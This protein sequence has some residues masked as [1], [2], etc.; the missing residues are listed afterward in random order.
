MLALVAGAAVLLTSHRGA[1]AYCTAP[2][3]SDSVLEWQDGECIGYSDGK[4]VFGEHGNDRSSR[5][6]DNLVAVQHLIARQ[7]ACAEVLHAHSPSSNRPFVT[8][9]YF[10][11]FSAPSGAASDWA[12]SQVAGLEG[13]LTWQRH[14]NIISYRSSDPSCAAAPAETNPQNSAAYLGEKQE[15]GGP[16]VRVVLANGGSLMHS[17]DHVGQLLVRFAKK[18]EENVASVIGLHRT[19]ATTKQA[20]KTLGRNGIITLAT[21]LSGD[22][23]V[24][25]SQSYFPLV[26][27]NRRQAL[28]VA[29]Y[30]AWTNRRQ[31][32]VYFPSNDCSGA[33]TPP[34]DDDYIKD[35]VLD[36]PVQAAGIDVNGLPLQVALHGW[37][38]V[39]ACQSHDDLLDYFRRECDRIGAGGDGGN[40]LVYFAGRPENFADFLN[41]MAGCLETSTGTS[42]N[43]VLV[44][45]DDTVTGY[46]SE[47]AGQ[48][49]KQVIFRLVS[50]APAPMLAGASCV[51]GGLAQL[52][53]SPKFPF[54]LPSALPELCTRLNAMFYFTTNSPPAPIG[55]SSTPASSP[56]QTDPHASTTG[57][58]TPT[59]SRPSANW[60]DEETALAYD[61]AKLTLNAV[62]RTVDDPSTM[63]DLN[64]T[65]QSGRIDKLNIPALT[66]WIRTHPETGATGTSDYNDDGT[67]DGKQL[68]VL[69]INLSDSTLPDARWPAR[70]VTNLEA[71]PQSTCKF[72]LS[73]TPPRATDC[74]G[75]LL[76]PPA[77]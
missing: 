39:V 72:V 16:I 21:A 58:D 32:D 18:P 4:F 49:S 15:Q 36:T 3:G 56:L 51:S 31:I 61:A 38:P 35:L 64:A 68:A 8:L 67:S 69:R 37:K 25:L 63:D 54:R 29:R 47:N 44:L 27:Q 6:V 65:C 9:V 53:D 57:P 77:R 34:E 28:L 75:R 14:Q 24:G 5:S 10:G 45:G 73:G 71:D 30:A 41:G 17:A 1:G 52:V 62:C 26:P 46:V 2:K 66:A 42:P 11:E 60:V 59:L 33:A 50:Q 12:G 20:I 43:G 22:D 13:L 19:N 7:N 48:D 74:L 76:S 55:L 23:L 70:A 40:H